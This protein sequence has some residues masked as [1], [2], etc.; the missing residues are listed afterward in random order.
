MIH[1]TEA[2][3][4]WNDGVVINDLTVSPQAKLDGVDNLHGLP[5]AED[6][7]DSATGRDG[8]IPR[9]SVRRGK[10]I[11]YNGRV[12]AKTLAEMRQK[13]AAVS[14]AFLDLTEGSMLVSPNPLYGL[15]VT[16]RFRARSLSFTP[17]DEVF[18]PND[19]WPFQ[20]PFVVALRMSDARFYD[21]NQVIANTGAIA[22]SVGLAPPFTP[23]FTLPAPG[24]GA[25]AAIVTNPGNAPSDPVIDIYGPATNPLIEN[26][27]IGRILKFAGISLD[28]TTFIRVDFASRRILLQGSSDFRAKLDRGA[29]DW[30]DAG[31]P[32]LPPG[33]SNV[34]LRGDAVTDPA[35]AT[36]TF[37]PAY[38][39]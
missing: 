17:G 16:R 7:R 31:V 39:A 20:H 23:P 37:N 32:G 10:T 28:A 33:D 15:G 6:L 24:Q 2:T 35:H 21:P 27:T 4:Q 19:N 30:W 1:A 14:S 34:R 8:E 18:D 38:V 29:S 9:R 36:I 26:T 12:R 11:A 22:A 25:G 13:M 3:H 5:E